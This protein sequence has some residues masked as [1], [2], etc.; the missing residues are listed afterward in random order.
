MDYFCALAVFHVEMP[1]FAVVTVRDAELG[2]PVFLGA[3]TSS[4]CHES[5]HQ[6]RRSDVKLHPLISCRNKPN[7][8]LNLDEL[9]QCRLS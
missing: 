8:L 2:D 4:F 5:C 1:V 6:S 3:V 7:C 9:S